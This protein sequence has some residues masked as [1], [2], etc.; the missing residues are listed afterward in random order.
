LA[1]KTLAGSRDPST[2]QTVFFANQTGLKLKQ[3]KITLQNGEAQVEAGAL[4]FMQGR[5]EIETEPLC[6]ESA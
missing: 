5:I 6:T 3:V 2:A 1:Y 4:H